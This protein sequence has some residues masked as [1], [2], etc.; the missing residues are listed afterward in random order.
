MFKLKFDVQKLNDTK[1]TK[2]CCNTVNLTSLQFSNGAVWLV[3]VNDGS[4]LSILNSFNFNKIKTIFIT[5][6]TGSHIYGLIG[7]LAMLQFR[8]P[9]QVGKEKETIYIVGPKGLKHYCDTLLELAD[10]YI[11]FSNMEFVEIESSQEVKISID[12]GKTDWRVFAHFLNKTQI[13]YQFKEYLPSKLNVEK[14]KNEKI[15][16]KLTSSFIKNKKIEWN[17]KSYHLN[18]YCFDPQLKR[19]FIFIPSLEGQNSEI[20]NQFQNEKFD[21]IIYEFKNSFKHKQIDSLLSK[22]IYKIRMGWNTI[23]HS[24]EDVDIPKVIDIVKM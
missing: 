3:N 20:L 17:G 5:E 4:Q 14:M 22:H 23:Q 19:N 10:T 18:D 6:L 7:L 16:L 8:Y 21:V 12:Q 11:K 15:P 2:Y 24:D 9:L 13:I 1:C